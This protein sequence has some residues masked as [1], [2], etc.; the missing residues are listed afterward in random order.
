MYINGA[1]VFIYCIDLRGRRS[2]T[3]PRYGARVPIDGTLSGQL[4]QP[5][6]GRNTTDTQ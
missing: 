2:R 4:P 1:A 6:L 5:G 3:E